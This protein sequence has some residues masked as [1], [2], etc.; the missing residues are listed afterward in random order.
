MVTV[1]STTVRGPYVV[2]QGLVLYLDASNTRSYPGS[3]T[4]WTNLATSASPATLTNSPTYNSGNAGYFDFDGVNDLVSITSLPNYSTSI[5][6]ISMWFRGSSSGRLFMQYNNDLN[7]LAI[8]YDSINQR[9]EIFSGYSTLVL[10]FATSNNTVPVNTWTNVTF[11][12]NFTTDSFQIFLNGIFSTS[13]TNS[14]VPT[15]DS[16]GEITLAAGK[17]FDNAPPYYFGY[18]TGRIAQTSI[19]NRVLS[20]SEIA[21]N[22]MAMKTRFGY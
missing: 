12:Y 11:T 16:M 15:P 19:Y 5:G 8:I 10:S 9:I 7:R 21:L 20:S 22:Y 17:D 14:V 1:K 6:T 4:I 3:G 18:Y 13:T 2:T